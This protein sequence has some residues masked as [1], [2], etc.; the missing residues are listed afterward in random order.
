[1]AENSDGFPPVTEKSFATDFRILKVSEKFKVFTKNK[2]Q[3]ACKEILGSRP[4]FDQVDLSFDFQDCDKDAKKV[5]NRKKADLAR[6]YDR[7][8]KKMRANVSNGRPQ[9]FGLDDKIFISS[10]KYK[11][12]FPPKTPAIAAIERP[13]S[14]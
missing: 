8:E 6:D 7:L 1:M 4:E 9:E 3:V 2:Y 13:P 11:V 12:L 14:R 10:A 5:V